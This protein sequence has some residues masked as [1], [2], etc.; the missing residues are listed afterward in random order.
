M[1]IID[2]YL[3]WQFVQMF[4]ICYISL[5]GLFVVIDAFTN[6]DHFMTFARNQDAA[7]GVV[8]G[9]YYAY[10]AVAIFDQTSGILALVAAMFTVTWIERYNEL[11]AL[12]AAGVSRLRVLRPVIL[13]A[14]AIGVLAATNREIVMPQIR[15]HL[16]VDT[17]NIGG[18]QGEDV[19]SRSDSKTDI[20]IDGDEAIVSTQTIIGPSFILPS[21]LSAYG[22]QLAAEQALYMPAEGNRPS[23][24]LLSGVKVPTDLKSKPS[25]LLDEQPVIVTPHDA[26]W[27]KPD[28]LYVVS[29]VD[30]ELLT[31][32]SEWRKYASTTELVAELQNPSIELGNDV[33]MAIHM[34]L[35]KP[36]MDGVLLFL[37][38]PL[39][40]SRS[41]RNP[42]VAIG[43]AI[44]VVAL[45][46]VVTLGSQSLG[47][48]GWIRP[49]LAAWLPLILFLPVGVFLA[50][51][52]KR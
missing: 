32:G 8:M 2:R 23:G 35:L 28:Q 19:F 52:L 29:D 3:L 31:G 6:I 30:F 25:L 39:V 36:F 40:V 11:T 20:R 22:K 26:S 18:D 49:A 10:R 17:R 46:F 34:R 9:K 24:Y 4:L 27:L 21:N 51:S 33:R 41:N 38:L 43:I 16:A 7:L 37:G 12:L 13:A 15:E 48:S 44:L 42:F 5:T 50:D 1:K 47:N 45:F 14:L